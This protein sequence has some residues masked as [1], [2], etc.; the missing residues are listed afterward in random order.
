MR[1][2]ARQRSYRLAHP[3]HIATQ[4]YYDAPVIEVCMT[5]DGHTGRGEAA[6]VD[7]RGESCESML[8]QILELDERVGERLLA[9]PVYLQE[10]LPAGGARNALDCA[11]WDLTAKWSGIDAFRRAAIACAKVETFITIGLHTPDAMAREARRLGNDA[12]IKIK[13]GGG[14]D[15]ACLRAIRSAVPGAT[16]MVD[17]NQ[18]WTYRTLLAMETE[19][20]AGN[21]TLVEQPLPAAA[22]DDLRDYHGELVLCADES[23]QDRSGL[24]SLVGKYDVVN[25]KLDKTGGLTEAL[26]LADA[27]SEL[28]LRL[29]VG[30]MGGS[31]L[32]I[33]PALVLAQRCDFIDLDCPLQLERDVE[34]GLHY[35]GRVIGCA[36]TAL[37]G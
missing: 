25:I 21:V 24:P 26:A 14:D 37:W 11:L 19:L 17:V 7:Y 2:A 5:Q 30:C 36:S 22:D 15:R 3:F 4:T 27:A 34:H 9:D 8:R 23:C 29:M 16:L 10:A 32:G 18:G 13:L 33:A 6:G 1:I 12:L 31:S 20:L 35:D 28:G